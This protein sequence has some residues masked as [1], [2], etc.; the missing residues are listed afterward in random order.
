MKKAALII[1]GL[2]LAACGASEIDT[3]LVEDEIRTGV[4]EQR[5]VDVTVDCPDTVE[6]EVGKTFQC[7]VEDPASGDQ[8]KADVTMDN[9]DGDIT[10]R[11]D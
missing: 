11:I 1:A 7:T 5:G 2:L 3:E 6:L 9:E 10:W 4:K 8:V